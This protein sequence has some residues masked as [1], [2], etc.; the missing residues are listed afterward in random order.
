MKY[1][2][3]YSLLKV[4]KKAGAWEK[5]FLVFLT[6]IFVIIVK[7]VYKRCCGITESFESGMNKNRA[8]VVKKVAPF[9]MIFIQRS[10]I[11]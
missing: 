11:I 10:M 9:M 3:P 1:A 2:T 8:L 7:N 5:T 6:L 4:F